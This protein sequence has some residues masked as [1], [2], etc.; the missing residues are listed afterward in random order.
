MASVE[1]AAEIRDSLKRC[2]KGRLSLDFTYG[3]RFF[4]NSDV[5]ALPD[6][7]TN[8]D[9]TSRRSFW[10]L[11]TSYFIKDN[12]SVG[13]EMN[14][15]ILPREQEINFSTFEGSGNGGVAINLGISSKYYFNKT[16]LFRPYIGIVIGS[17]SLRAISGEGSI[18]GGQ[19]KTTLTSQ[20]R[21][22]KIQTGFGCRLSPGLILDYNLGLTRTSK[23]D[24]IGGVTS[25]GGISTSL[26]LHFVLNHKN[27]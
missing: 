5:P 21:S 24:L 26:N 12:W 8:V 3:Q 16:E 2:Y 7:I 11:G 14:F 15:T 17:T 27:H 9:F 13:L 23:T 19:T 4:L 18:T 22:A 25:Y 1:T 10:G 6:T 20:L